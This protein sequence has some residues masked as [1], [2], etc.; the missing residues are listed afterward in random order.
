MDQTNTDTNKPK[1]PHGGLL[2]I[3]WQEII[4]S[5]INTKAMVS[6]VVIAIVSI[7]LRWSPSK[8]KNGR[9]MDKKMYNNCEQLL[10]KHTT[11]GLEGFKI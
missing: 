1:Q 2:E 10:Y 7:Y 8:V 11:L 3:P 5:T 4:N 9:Q 6:I